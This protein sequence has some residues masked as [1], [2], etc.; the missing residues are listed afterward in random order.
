MAAVDSRLELLFKHAVVGT[1]QQD[2]RRG[3]YTTLPAG[4]GFGGGRTSPGNYANTAHN[5]PLVDAVLSDPAVQRVARYVD[6]GLQTYWPKLHQFLSNLLEHILMDCPDIRRLFAGCCYGACHLN[7]HNAATLDHE[8]Y[9]NILFA[10]CAVY[11][12]GK[13]D[14]TRSG[15]LIAWSLGIVAQF[16]AGS[17]AFLPSACVTHANTPIDSK[18]GEHRSSIAFFTSAGLAR[19]YH[20][21]YMSDKEFME[22]ASPRQLSAWKDYRSRLWKAGLELLQ[23]D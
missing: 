17:A 8:D 5:E 23:Y 18:S 7:L 1:R 21:G 20:N 16:P 10:L 13:Y 15:H 6:A 11:A 14:H 3:K 22:R 19:W 12:S 4:C 9:Y 2:H